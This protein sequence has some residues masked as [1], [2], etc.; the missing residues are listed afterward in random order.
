MSIPQK[1]RKEM[2]TRRLR[3]RSL[4]V[5]VLVAV[6]A[7]ATA[8]AA[9]TSR[10]KTAGTAATSFK[11]G[12]ST[13]FLHDPFMALLQSLTLKLAK[14]QGISTLQP[15]NANQDPA[16]QITDI[17]TLISEGAQSLIVIPTD[18]KAVLPA[19]KYANSK[20]VPVVTIDDAPDGGGAYMVVRTDN[21]L[22]GVTACKRMG[23]LL[24]GKGTVLELQGDLATVNGRDR[25][26]GFES[27]MKQNYPNVKIIAR[28]TKWQTPLAADAAQTIV[29][30][31]PDLTG[32][33]MESDSVMLTAV[34]NVL[35]ASHKD[36]KIGEKGHIVLVTIDGT[37]PA[38]KAIRANQ[39]D[40]V[41]S[42]PLDL[43]AKYGVFYARAAVAGKKFKLGPTS[44]GSKIVM[45]QGNQE[46]ALPGPL[47]TKKNVDDKSLWGNS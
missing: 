21:V 5:V 12:Y 26:T 2:H 1:R 7:G 44:H 34:L 4:L 10:S 39:V 31:T 30:S 38:L 42:Q 3:G 11:L 6:V 27:C 19:V 15:A 28:P 20:K 45:F 23:A 33:Y 17:H 14:A 16:K 24:K 35:K 41:V 18:G 29:T 32:I 25:T 13:K 36:A 22:M 47:V 43:Y 46:D 8:T 40:G 9:S 37:P